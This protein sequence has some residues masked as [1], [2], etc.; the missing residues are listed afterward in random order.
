MTNTAPTV[1][2]RAFLKS[3]ALAGGGLAIAVAWPA[4][5][6]KSALAQSTGS[7]A[8]SVL[9]AYLTI[10]TD[11]TVTIQAP[12]PEFG[13]NVITSMPMIVAEELDVDWEAVAVEQAPFDTALYTN[14]FTGGSRGIYM[15]WERLRTAGAAA[16]QMLRVAAADAWGVPVE[17][18]TTDAGELRHEPSGRAASYGELASAAAGVPVPEN[19]ELKG[20]KDFR[21][22]GTSQKN[23]VGREIVTGGPLFGM[24]FKRDGMLVAMIAKPPAFGMKLKSVDDSAAR[25]MPGIRDVVTINTLREDDERNLFDTDAFPE[26][27][28][29]VG[30]STWQVMNARKALEL[31]WEPIEGSE[32]TITFFGNE[33]VV[34]TPAGLESSADHE[35][36]MTE[37]S[38]AGAEELRRDGDPEA[39]FENAAKVIERTYSAPYLA[40]NTME[41]MNF[42]A[43]VTADRAEVAGPLQAPEFIEQTLATRL[44]LPLDAIDIHM[45]R[46]GGGFGRR[47]YS[48]HLIE[49]ALISRQVKAPVKLIYS[50][51]DDMTF[52]IYRP[53]YRVTYKAALDADNNLVAFH[54]RG[55]GVPEHPVF[56]NRFPAGA[57]DNF[58]AE[59][60]AVDSNITIGAFRAPRSNFIGGAEQ[61]FFD[62]V[63]EAAG[64]DPIEFRLELLRRAKE[65]PVGANN[66][67]DPER[68]AGVLELVREKSDWGNNA[69]LGVH[70][71]VAAYFCHNSY[72]AHVLDLVIEDKRPVVRS[73]CSAVD[74]GIVVNPDAATNMVEGAVIDGIGNALHGSMTFTDGV[75]DKQNFDSYR[76]IRIGEAPESID[77]YFVPS[78]VD[79]T[80]LGEPPFPPIFG[81]LANALHKATGERFYDQPFL[82]GES[83]L[84]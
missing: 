30:D 7:P 26:L 82:G 72:V 50:R 60:W 37:A 45:T 55:G 23:V 73:V 52:G 11:G 75:P 14:Q 40:H 15:A 36:M 41:P 54:I 80:G 3:S 81:A 5:E 56:P 74:C 64:K 10:A 46:M 21:I 69:G 31:E 24:D 70:R 27:V 17:D 34:R 32:R 29:V 4:L 39:A 25:S 2:R 63:A 28:A 43:D 42:F 47:A 57:V 76:M 13:Q 79:P 1:N 71:G 48:H 16:R 18:V 58:L 22:V 35:R 12:N 65:R 20:R 38:A 6:Q 44:G 68:Y 8:A 61:S 19:I 51:E 49:A 77:V 67:Y 53:T 59:G 83:T 66:E 9:N 78:D 84:G 62:E 33:T